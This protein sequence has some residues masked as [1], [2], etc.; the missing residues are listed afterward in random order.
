MEE[1]YGVATLYTVHRAG[2][3]YCQMADHTGAYIWQ[4]VSTSVQDPALDLPK[5]AVGWRGS[6]FNFGR[7]YPN[8]F[9]DLYYGTSG[10]RWHVDE[11]TGEIY[12]PMSRFIGPSSYPQVSTGDLKR[13]NRIFDPS[14][15]TGTVLHQGDDWV[16]ILWDKGGTRTQVLSA[17]NH[18]WWLTAR[19]AWKGQEVEGEELFG[20]LGEQ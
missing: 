9:A 20:E 11:G 5:P 7:L 8:V 6:R 16:T 17:Q 4:V 1:Y 18:K 12:N 2:Q 15:Q 14:L 19:W 3:G 13:G 10:E